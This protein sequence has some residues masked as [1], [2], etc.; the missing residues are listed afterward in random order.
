MAVC[1]YLLPHTRQQLILSFVIMDKRKM[2]GQDGGLKEKSRSTARMDARVTKRRSVGGH[3]E[4]DAAREE[5]ER[6][7]RESR[8]ADNDSIAGS[9]KRW[10]GATDQARSGEKTETTRS[11]GAA[12]SRN[13]LWHS[14]PAT[15]ERVGRKCEEG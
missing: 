2:P 15:M 1:A 10:Q 12:N 8:T 9:L 11:R 13:G 4:D 6:A 3:D 5:S 14:I 7:W